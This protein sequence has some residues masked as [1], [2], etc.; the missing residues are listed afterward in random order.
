VPTTLIERIAAFLAK[1]VA[2]AVKT[3]TA[4]QKTR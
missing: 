2:G 4:K 1:E 3:K